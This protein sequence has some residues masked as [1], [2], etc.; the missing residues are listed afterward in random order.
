MGR[1]ATGRNS[2]AAK[3]GLKPHEKYCLG[4]SG[5]VLSSALLSKLEKV[6]KK[7]W[8]TEGVEIPDDVILGKCISRH[9]DIQCAQEDSV[10]INVQIY[11]G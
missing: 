11:P 4:S 2:E 7:C 8:E 5:I 9:L 1:W 3:L 10:R 6:L